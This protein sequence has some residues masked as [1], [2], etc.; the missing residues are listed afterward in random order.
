MQNLKQG[1]YIK[2]ENR[3]VV[4]PG[5]EVGE[6]EKCSSKRRKLRLFRVSK[7]IDLMYSLMTIVNNTVL[8]I[9]NLL[10]Q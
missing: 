3:I 6:M 7:S 8:A 9:G 2:A 1:K 4:T 5:R 10:R